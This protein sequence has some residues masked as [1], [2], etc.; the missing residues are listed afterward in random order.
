MMGEGLG[1]EW[2]NKK[3]MVRRKR[4]GGGGGNKKPKPPPPPT[5]STTCPER[6]WHAAAAGLAARSA[7]SQPTGQASAPRTAPF[8]HF[9]G[10]APTKREGAGGGACRQGQ[11]RIQWPR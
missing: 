8:P 7:A 1:G 3:K 9:P 2:G 11:G 10:T 4:E 6:A 5:I